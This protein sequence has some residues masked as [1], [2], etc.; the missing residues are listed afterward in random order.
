MSKC[1][2]SNLQPNNVYG[3][4]GCYADADSLGSEVCR[5][6]FTQVHKL[7]A[8][9]GRLKDKD[10]YLFRFYQSEFRRVRRSVMWP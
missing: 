4:E 7:Y 8:L 3:T 2:G 6:D 9:E 5:K 1:R 10:I